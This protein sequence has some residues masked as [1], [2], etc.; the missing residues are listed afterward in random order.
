MNKIQSKIMS[1]IK[2]IAKSKKKPF[3][4]AVILAGGTS[5]RMNGLSKQLACVG[6]IP[7]IVRSALAYENCADVNEII[8]VCRKEEKDE[9]EAM[10]G[11]YKITKFKCF[12]YGGKTRFDSVRNGFEK[13]SVNADIVAVHDAARCLILPEQISAVIAAAK[14]NG[15]AIAA[16]PS[17]DTVKI[18]DDDGKIKSTPDRATLWNAQTPQTFI[19]AMLEVGLYYPR[20]AAFKPTDDAVLVETLGFKVAV[21]DCGYEN[22][23]IT[24]PADIAVAE[25]IVKR[26]CLNE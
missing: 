25:N 17:V 26:R 15:A 23:K 18:V 19:R 2:Q 12:A 9:V 22:I 8:V 21:V 14:K 16:A 11:K 1:V 7:V 24:T 5:E 6:G 4:S 3:A 20:E 13:T 10:L